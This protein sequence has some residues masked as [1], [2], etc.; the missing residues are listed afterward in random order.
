MAKKRHYEGSYEGLENA[1]NMER[2]DF[3]MISEDRSAIANL[4]QSVKYTSWPKSS[5]YHDYGLDDTISG[6]NEQQRKDNSKMEKHLQPE[7]Y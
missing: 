3:S 4:P 2:K 7:K 5:H 1:R 6:I